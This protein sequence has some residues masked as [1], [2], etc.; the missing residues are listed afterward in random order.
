[1]DN[2]PQIL[3]VSET[4]VAEFGDGRTTVVEKITVEEMV[5]TRVSTI[6]VEITS[7]A[8]HVFAFVS[9]ERAGTLR[10]EA[11]AYFVEHKLIKDDPSLELFHNKIQLDREKTLGSQGIVPGS[12]LLLASTVPP[13]DG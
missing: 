4:I 7:G 13:V 3:E 8:D 5:E 9:E 11:I 6:T 1:M 10:L 2:E 12:K